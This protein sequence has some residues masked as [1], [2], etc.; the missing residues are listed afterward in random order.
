MDTFVCNCLDCRKVTA[1]MFASNFTVNDSS[2]KHERGEDKLTKFAQSKTIASGSTM[3]NSFCS[4]CGTLMYRRSTRFPGASILR[5]GT[6]DDYNLH[7][8]KLKP[9]F[10][11]FVKSRVSWFTGVD[12]AEQHMNSYI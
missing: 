8:T 12:G 4:K 5:I 10:E 7:E 9:K 11:S 3:E 6:V 2:L 1:S